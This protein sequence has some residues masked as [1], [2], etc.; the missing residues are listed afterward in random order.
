[1]ATK[2]PP[3][4]SLPAIKAFISLIFFIMA[5]CA[6]TP[7]E[8]GTRIALG[9]IVSMPT[10]EIWLGHVTAE[11]PVYEIALDDSRQTLIGM[12]AMRLRP[13]ERCPYNGRPREQ[14]FR[15][16]YGVSRDESVFGAV[17]HSALAQHLMTRNFVVRCDLVG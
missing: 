9:R 16:E 1:M 5:S 11:G 2:L 17:D 7:R 12:M 8:E 14:L 4:Q 13:T 10:V 3:L 6:S 15:I